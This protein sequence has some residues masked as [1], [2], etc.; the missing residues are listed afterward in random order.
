MTTRTSGKKK[1]RKSQEGLTLE[2]RL[3]RAMSHP[4]RAKILAMLN[5]NPASSS[6]L[7]DQL[8][9]PLSNISYHVK[10]LHDWELVE[11]IRK[12]QVR[13]AL[14][15]TYR[16]RSTSDPTATSSLRFLI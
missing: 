14:K 3:A 10:E 5:T 7:E 9:V 16:G 11:A 12:E 4:L 1:G 6:E 15:T 2:E 8:D 13:G